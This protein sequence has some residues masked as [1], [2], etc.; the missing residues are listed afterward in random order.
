M[1]AT[2]DADG[3]LWVWAENGLESYALEHWTHENDPGGRENF[4]L[5]IELSHEKSP[6]KKGEGDH[7]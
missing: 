6:E 3:T 5:V 1:R 2:I 7:G 4:N